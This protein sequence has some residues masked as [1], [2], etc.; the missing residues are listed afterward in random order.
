M[1]T[2]TPYGAEHQALVAFLRDRDLG[3]LCPRCR[4]P[5]LDGQELDAGHS[6]DLAIDPQ[7]KADQLEHASCNRRAGQALSVKRSKLKPSRKW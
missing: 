2:A 4:L 3:K 6:V 7:S 5:M 1:A